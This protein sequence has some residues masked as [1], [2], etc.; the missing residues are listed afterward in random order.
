MSL[1]HGANN[2][3]RF[4]ISGGTETTIGSDTILTFTYSGSSSIS[5]NGSGTASVLVVGGGGGSIYVGGGGGGD[6][7]E[8]VL[9]FNT[10]TYLIVGTG[11]SGSNAVTTPGFDSK[12]VSYDGINTLTAKGGGYGGDAV[13]NGGNGGSGGGAADG[14]SGVPSGY[15]TNYGGTGGW[16]SFGFY[17]VGGGGGGAGGPGFSGTTFYGGTGG[18]GWPS[19]ISGTLKYYGAGGGGAVLSGVSGHT[20]GPGGSGVGGTGADTDGAGFPPTNGS[21]NTGSGAGGRGLYTVQGGS[22]IVIIRYRKIE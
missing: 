5:V 17:Y 2:V 21:P 4:I 6:V 10:S 18:A 12:I 8:G 16:T 15:N 11:G 19:S 14:L 22:G 20:P 13:A 1:L 3:P 9:A 7:Y